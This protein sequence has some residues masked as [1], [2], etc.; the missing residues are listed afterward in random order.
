MTGTRKCCTSKSGYD[1]LIRKFTTGERRNL[2]KFSIYKSSSSN[3]YQADKC[4][5]VL[6]K[7]IRLILEKGNHKG[8]KT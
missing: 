7:V 5:L 1:R 2:S 3:V 8:K 4:E 6:R